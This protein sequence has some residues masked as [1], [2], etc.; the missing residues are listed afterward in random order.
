MTTKVRAYVHH[1]ER[2]Y[3][4]G[5]EPKTSASGVVISTDRELASGKMDNFILTTD[6]AIDLAIDIL[7]NAKIARRVNAEREAKS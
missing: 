6:E 7:T 3:T 5:A 1:P 4:S 2:R